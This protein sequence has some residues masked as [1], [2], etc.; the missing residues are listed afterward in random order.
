[1][2]IS[3]TVTVHSWV[4]VSLQ[5]SLTGSRRSAQPLTNLECRSGN[6]V[7]RITVVCCR[8]SAR[9]IS[10]CSTQQR[11]YGGQPACARPEQDD[12]VQVHRSAE[13]SSEAC[14]NYMSPHAHHVIPHLYRRTT[15][16]CCGN[17]ICLNN[18]AP[19]VSSCL[20][21]YIKLSSYSEGPQL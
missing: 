8:V 15:E 21:I 16:N 20:D 18:I 13:A 12:V 10:C 1:M 7:L 5:Q 4:H 14:E 2:P 19:P 6:C 9:T 11:G 17:I 3:T